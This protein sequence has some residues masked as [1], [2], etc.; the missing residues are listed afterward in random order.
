MISRNV[1]Y[2]CTPGGGVADFPLCNKECNSGYL[3][4]EKLLFQKNTVFVISASSNVASR[5]T[6]PVVAFITK[7][8][9]IT[10]KV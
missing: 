7:V 10:L 4:G 2:K 5:G 1:I 8:P 6:V 3:M 9:T